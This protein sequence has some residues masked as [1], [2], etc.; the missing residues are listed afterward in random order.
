MEFSTEY[1]RRVEDG[2]KEDKDVSRRG[3][4]PLKQVDRQARKMDRVRGEGITLVSIY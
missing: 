1:Q 4:K 3:W 2:Q